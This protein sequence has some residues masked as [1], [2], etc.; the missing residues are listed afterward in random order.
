M[1]VS[2]ARRIRGLRERVYEPSPQLDVLTGVLAV[3]HLQ[4]ATRRYCNAS[5]AQFSGKS[6]HCLMHQFQR[7]PPSPVSQLRYPASTQASTRR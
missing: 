2:G 7:A 4:Y 1:Q 6:S 5:A 3:S